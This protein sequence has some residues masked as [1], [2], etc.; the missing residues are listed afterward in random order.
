MESLHSTADIIRKVALF[1]LVGFLVVF[2]I[3]PA[4][5]VVGVILPFALVGFLVWLPFRVLVQRREI[6]WTGLPEKAGRLVRTVLTLPFRVGAAILSIPLRILGL[7]LTGVVGLLRL[8]GGALGFALRITIPALAGAVVFALLGAIGG[9][10][11]HDAEFRV[12]AAALIGA[13]IGALYGA[14]R[15]KTVEKVIVLR[16]ASATPNQG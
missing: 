8:V 2:L 14:F 3:G 12:P 6:N 5:T 15:T 7:L 4:L 10:T 16:P 13:A 1:T 11:H 9:M